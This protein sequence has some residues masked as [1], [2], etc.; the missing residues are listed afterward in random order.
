MEEIEAL[1]DKVRSASSVVK[2]MPKL[3][4][5]GNFE[6]PCSISEV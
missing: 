3:E 5:L 6:V 2:K 4:Y 1:F